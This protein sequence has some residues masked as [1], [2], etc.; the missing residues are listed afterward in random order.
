MAYADPEAS[1]HKE[2]YKQR[3]LANLRRRAKSLGYVLQVTASIPPVAE[4]SQE[5]GVRQMSPP[6]VRVLA[7]GLVPA[8]C[9]LSLRSFPT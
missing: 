2:R 4:V 6:R 3:V 7:S 5:M 8:P 9:Q 1:Y